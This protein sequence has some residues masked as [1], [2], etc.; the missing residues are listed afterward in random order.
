MNSSQQVKDK[1]SMRLN[2][3]KERRKIVKRS[4]GVQVL[5]NVP[6]DGRT[7][8]FILRHGYPPLYSLDSHPH[9]DMCFIFKAEMCKSMANHSV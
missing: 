3:S 6:A 9:I 5:L 7:G 1:A 8:V 2:G 4:A